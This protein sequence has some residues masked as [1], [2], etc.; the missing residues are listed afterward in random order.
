MVKTADSR[1]RSSPIEG[2]AWD[3][4][5]RLDRSDAMGT[6]EGRDLM[7]QR[8]EIVV[9]II[10][11]NSRALRLENEING[12]DIQTLNAK[13]D[14]E[15]S[16]TEDNRKNLAD[17]EERKRSLEDQRSALLVE[18]QW[19]DQALDDFDMASAGAPLSRTHQA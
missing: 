17:I 16:E 12:L 3:Q 10:E 14:I 2:S 11:A 8:H 1:A 13:R 18:K 7:L 15:L 6:P 5:V 9:R 19:L 4:W